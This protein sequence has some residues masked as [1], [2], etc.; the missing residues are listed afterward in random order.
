MIKKIEDILWDIWYYIRLPWYF[1]EVKYTRIER[2]FGKRKD[3]SVIPEG[4]YCYTWDEEREIRQPH[5]N[6]GFWIKSC[7]YYR[8][9]KGQCDAGC[10]YVG[11]MGFDPC[12]G[13]QCKICGQNYGDDR[14]PLIIEREEKIEKI[15]KRRNENK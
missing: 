10:T 4:M 15:T 14:D 6:G 2:Y 11:F 8:S 13:D 1:I 7:K 5:N 12:L 9:M 3:K